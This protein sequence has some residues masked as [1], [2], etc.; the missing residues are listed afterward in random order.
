MNRLT[1]KQRIISALGFIVLILLIILL[2]IVYPVAK[3]IHQLQKDINKIEV[4]LE[5]RYENSQKLQRTV[6][7]IGQISKET[8]LLS[9]IMIKN[10]EELS[11]ITELEALAEKYH[12]VQNLNVSLKEIATEERR[13]G[14][15]KYYLLTFANEGRFSDHVKYLADLEKNSLYIITDNVRWEKTKANKAGDQTVLL[16][17]SSIIYVDPESTNK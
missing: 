2:F 11:L 15:T 14:F 8:N 10:G 5:K 7:E 9:Q 6:R 4:E 17:F 12:I 1:L 16:N 13:A 3:K